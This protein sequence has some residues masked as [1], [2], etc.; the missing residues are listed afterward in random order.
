MRIFYDTEFLEDGVALDLISLGAIREDGETFY[1]ESSDFDRNRMT[2][3][4]RRHVLPSLTGDGIPNSQ[5]ARMFVDFCGM[6]PEFW[7][8]YGAYDWVIMRRLYGPMIHGPRHWPKFAMDIKQ[9]AVAKGNP[10]LP[11][12]EGTNH[13]ALDDAKW[14]LVAW[15]FLKDYRRA[16]KLEQT[17][18]N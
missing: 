11:K 9:M 16:P 6:K 17:P 15:K 14:N 18:A 13:N 3:W 5:I 4:L 12:Q 1:A 10:E 8:Y 7:T 2:P